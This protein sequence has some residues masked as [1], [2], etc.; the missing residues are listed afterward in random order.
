MRIRR[1]GRRVMEPAKQSRFGVESLGTFR[2][3]E[4][5]VTFVDEFGFPHVSEAFEPS[6]EYFLTW[7]ELRP[8]V[9]SQGPLS[10]IVR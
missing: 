6:E 7:K 8:F 1:W 3:D 4:K 5:G 9:N 10:R 2:L